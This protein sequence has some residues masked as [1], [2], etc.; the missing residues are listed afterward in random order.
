MTETYRG[1]CF[2]GGVEIEARGA[3]Q[4]MGYCHCGSCRAHSGGPVNAFTLWKA[5][6]VKVTR[7]EDRLANYNKTDFSGRRYC[8]DCGGHV[9]VDHPSLGMIDVHAAIIP[10][11]H[12]QPAV[13]LHYQETVL[14]MK[15]GLPKYRDFP[16]DVG[17]SG[18][19]MA[20]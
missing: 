3:P 18:E 14:P 12:F 16:V 2:C 9:M 11:L 6:D 15:D 4:A 1:H 17:G 7:G 19:M 8:A 10:D 13:H 5:D 20:E